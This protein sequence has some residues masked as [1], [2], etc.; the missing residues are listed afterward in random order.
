M[1]P[2]KRAVSTAGLGLAVLALG[3]VSDRP[4][5]AVAGVAVLGW[6]LGAQLVAVW[7]FDRT[8]SGLTVEIVPDRGQV[9]AD[10][11]V[12][13]AVSASA[14][15]PPFGETTLTV[16]TPLGAVV[17]DGDRTVTLASGTDHAATTVACRFQAPGEYTV[18]EPTVTLRDSRGLF[19][20]TLTHGAPTTVTVTARHPERIHVG[21]AG[22]RVATAYGQ[23]AAAHGSGGTTPA[24]LREYAPGDSVDQIDWNA[25]A[26]LGDPYVREFEAETDRETH[27]VVDHRATTDAGRAGTTA[28]DYAR[29]VALGLVDAA[30]AAGDPVG[31]WTVGD[32]GL[33]GRLRAGTDPERYATV[34]DR[35][36]DLSPTD[37]TAPED[38][39]G[40]GSGDI[41]DGAVAATPTRQ[42]A[43][44][45]AGARPAVARR[46]GTRLGDDTDPFARRLRPFFTETQTYVATMASRPLYGTLERLRSSVSGRPLI[47]VVTDDTHRQETRE[48]IRQAAG[49][50]D[51]LVFL[52]PLVLYGEQSPADVERAYGEYV[53]FEEFRRELSRLAGV[54][55][56]EVGPE[57]R[58]DSLLRAGAEG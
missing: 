57:D 42:P 50:A 45:S 32:R 51:L 53:D 22:D 48:A 40:D 34:R 41:P 46:R 8:V 13:L 5:I 55:A 7:Q 52:T 23:H 38:A 31:C 43:R 44:T 4:V 16:D 54:E 58:V 24:E 25:T 11:P 20:E 15:T 36:R 9:L 47:V 56:Y 29:G 33:T 18:P 12:R 14:A 30:E 27:L 21:Q 10:D 3:V 28:L 37:A 1:Y 49:S 35:L 19:R 2:T 6:L 39:R 26:R 17:D